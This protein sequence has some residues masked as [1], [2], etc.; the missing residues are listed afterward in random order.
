MSVGLRIYL[1]NER[2]GAVCATTD[3]GA[4]SSK[5]DA[6]RAARPV[7]QYQVQLIAT[8]EG[9]WKNVEAPER[10]NRCCWRLLYTDKDGDEARERDQQHI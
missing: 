7:R 2:A 6:E 4:Y 1:A 9:R 5:R 3:D 10:V 8:T